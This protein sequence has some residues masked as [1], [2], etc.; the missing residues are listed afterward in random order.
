MADSRKDGLA[1]PT[2]SYPLQELFVIGQ[3]L[4]FLFLF[5]ISIS[6]SS[7]RTICPPLDTVINPLADF[8][9]SPRL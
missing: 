1:F 2:Q 6:L 9:Y 3:C 4:V 7:A 5:S 8:L